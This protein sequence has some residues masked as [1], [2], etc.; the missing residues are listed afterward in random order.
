[1]RAIGKLPKSVLILEFIGM[2]LLM[3]ALLSL[4]HHLSLPVPFS[5]PEVQILMIFLGVLLML[6][7]AVVVILQVAKR[8]APQLMNRPLES[9]RSERE[10]DN[11]ANH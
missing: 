7:A 10:K 2:M 4:S 6:P 9:S 1:M 5:T 8:L 3:T 11:D